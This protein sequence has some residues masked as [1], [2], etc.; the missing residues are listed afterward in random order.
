MLNKYTHE[1]SA[2]AESDEV[3]RAATR[4]QAIARGR[5]SRAAGFRAREN[6]GS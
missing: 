2:V 5:A 1:L 3:V 6:V 4:I